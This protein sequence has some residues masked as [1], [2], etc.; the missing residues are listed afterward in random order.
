MEKNGKI[1][2]MK[3]NKIEETF[4]IWRTWEETPQMGGEMA[5]RYTEWRED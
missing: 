4:K 5:R 2:R 1:Q 3:N